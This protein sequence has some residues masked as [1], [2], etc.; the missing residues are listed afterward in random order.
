MQ[1]TD[2]IDR[3]RN[4]TITGEMRRE[5]KDFYGNY[6]SEGE[7]R[8]YQRGILWKRLSDGYPYGSGRRG[9]SKYVR[10]TQDVTPT[11]IASTASPFKFT[12]VMYAVNREKYENVQILNWWMSFRL[13]PADRFLHG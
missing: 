2:G 9:I 3:H 5:L 10:D 8:S 4:Y 1:R 7:T 13:Y 12:S 11:V 6:C